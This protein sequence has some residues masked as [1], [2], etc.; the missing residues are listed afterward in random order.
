MAELLKDGYNRP[1]LE[2]LAS[3]ISEQ[4]STF[5]PDIFLDQV[6]DETW[7]SL[8]LKQRMSHIAKSWEGPSCTLMNSNLR[9]FTLLPK[10]LIRDS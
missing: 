7:D 6:F 10:E 9:S 8:E 3:L 4:D 2:K 1:L 5:Q